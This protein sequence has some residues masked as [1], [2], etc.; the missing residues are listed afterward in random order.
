MSDLDARLAQR[1]QDGYS[2]STVETVPT[3]VAH[4]PHG[5]IPNTPLVASAISFALGAA[6]TVGG[7]LFVFGGLRQLAFTSQ[8]GFFIAAWA[9]FHWAEFAVTAGWNREKCS[10]DCEH[11]FLTSV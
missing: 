9:T 2:T 8:L 11:W 7:S 6:F 4:T 1:S 5:S 3:S 10:V